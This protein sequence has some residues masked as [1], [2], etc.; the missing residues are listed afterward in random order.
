MKKI[1]NKLKKKKVL[2]IVSI[3]LLL[4]VLILLLINKNKVRDNGYSLNFEKVQSPYVIQESSLIIDLEGNN[5]KIPK[6]DKALK[7]VSYDTSMY[8]SF[9]EKVI[10]NTDVDYIKGGYFEFSKNIFLIY[11]SDSNVFSFTSKKGIKEF[12]S[13][14]SEDDVKLFLKDNFEVKDAFIYEKE[15]VGSNTKYKGRYKVKGVE[16]GSSSL[17][18]YSFVLNIDKNGNIVEFLFLLLREDNVE[19]YQFIPI[20]PVKELISNEKYP[21]VIGQNTIENRYYSKPRSSQLIEVYVKEISLLYIYHDTEN[22]L[23]LPTY[24]LK[25]EGKV[26]DTEGQKYW[27]KTEILICAVN[28]KY[29]ITREPEKKLEALEE[30][31]VPYEHP[32]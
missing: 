7:V 30:Q 26:L 15:T 27:S 24:K 22:G 17:N 29:L 23:I 16:F 13:I 8:N 5:L 4:L 1:F 9:L 10:G 18:G 14:S 19:E 31:G 20:S 3:I 21:K 11:S 12:E 6:T 25:G 32:E 28:P 2:I